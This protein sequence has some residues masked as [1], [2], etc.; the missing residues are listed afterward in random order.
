MMS[1]LIGL[2][3]WLE[4]KDRCNH[5]W[6]TTIQVMDRLAQETQAPWMAPHKS[7]EAMDD[8][9]ES[10]CNKWMEKYQRQEDNIKMSQ[11]AKKQNELLAKNLMRKATRL[12]KQAADASAKADV[13]KQQATKSKK[14]LAKLLK[15][16]QKHEEE[17]EAEGCTNLAGT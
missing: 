10:K 11:E 16:R 14:K 12:A 13:A 15:Q 5:Q 6:P 1:L 17:A 3:C 7:S 8:E 4:G 9:A 2:L